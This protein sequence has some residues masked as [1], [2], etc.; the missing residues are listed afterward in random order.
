LL[1]VPGA[2]NWPELQNATSG[3]LSQLTTNAGGLGLQPKGG[4]FL[5]PS[6]GVFAPGLPTI[7]P[8]AGSSELWNDNGVVSIA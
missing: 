8:A 4:L 1:N 3:N 5:S 2:V 6:N 7:K